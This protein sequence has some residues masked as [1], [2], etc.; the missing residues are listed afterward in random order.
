MLSPPY[1]QELLDCS[2]IS[3]LPTPTVPSQGP[4]WLF[5]SEGEVDLFVE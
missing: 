3:P 5:P 4:P 2:N 1:L